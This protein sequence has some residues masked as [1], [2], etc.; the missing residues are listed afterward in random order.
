MRKVFKNDA[1]NKTFTKQGYVVVS[2]LTDVEVNDALDFFYQSGHHTGKKE[3]YTTTWLSDSELRLKTNEKMKNIFS[4]RLSELL[5][6]YTFFYGSYFVKESG[7]QGDCEAHQDWTCSEEPECSSVTVWCALQDVTPENG[8]L[9]ILPYSQN[10]P[11]YIRGRHTPDYLT[12][13]S[14]FVQKYLF[15]PIILK[16]GQAI[17]FNQRMIH[18]SFSNFSSALRIACGG[19]AAPA[20]RPVIHYVG[21]SASEIKKVSAENDLFS[22]YDTFD[23]MENEPA[24]ERISYPY[25]RLTKKELVGVICRAYLHSLFS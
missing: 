1:L 2:L 8:C 6:N 7:E 21:E 20:D 24:V 22:R 23:K 18:G 25:A 3:F 15:K 17:L 10:L 5:D 19:V 16:K 12:E 9:Q 13:V 11:N 4:A 14:A